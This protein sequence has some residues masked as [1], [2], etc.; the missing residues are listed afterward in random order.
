M[1]LQIR[2]AERKGRHTRLALVGPSGTGK[3][4]TSLLLASGLTRNGKICAIDTEHESLDKYDDILPNGASFSV[5]PL[6]YFSPENYIEAIA[7]VAKEGFDTLIIDSLSHGW[8]GE[9]GALDLVNK[10]QRRSQSNNSYVAWRDVTPLHNRLVDSIIQAPMHVIATLRAKTEYVMEKG[11]DGK[12]TVRKVGLAPVQRDGLEYEFDIVADMDTSN[13][14]IVSKSR[15]PFMSGAVVH[16]PGHDLG[17]SL[18][19][20]YDGAKPEPIEQSKPAVEP[21]LTRVANLMKRKGIKLDVL[22]SNGWENPRT[23]DDPTLEKLIQWLEE[24]EG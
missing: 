17:V 12:T 14:L 22:L 21:L 10:A 19:E 18:R 9:G 8:M 1:T 6:H 15:V 23:L 11:E 5:L 13:T 16:K 3:S 7:L 4:Y 24:F 20:W 2:K